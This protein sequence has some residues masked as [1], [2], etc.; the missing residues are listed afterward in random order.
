MPAV[1]LAALFCGTAVLSAA[2]RARPHAIGP[3]LRGILVGV[4]IVLGVFAFIGLRSN[5]AL[6]SS[7]SATAQGNYAKAASEA[8]AARSWAPWSA[9]PWQL[10]GE[11]QLALGKRAAAAVS[12]R[13]ALAK[14]DSNWWIWLD[15]A[16]AS[17][18]AARRHAIA[19]VTKLNPL[20]PEVAS[21]KTPTGGAG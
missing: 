5:L 7:R 11:A 1:T 3:V 15:L 6:A 19:E 17:K 12:L 10:L 9:D 13:R 8:K 4:V 2:K 14:D 20:G 21:L 16:E 18:G